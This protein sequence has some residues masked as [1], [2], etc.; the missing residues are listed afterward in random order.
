MTDALSAI[1]EFVELAVMRHRGQLPVEDR[2]KLEALEDVLRD[3]ID[4]SR[5]APRRIANPSPVAAPT[6]G[7]A[8]PPAQVVLTPT[9]STP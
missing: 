8:V 5:P 6:G 4:G 3:L 1:G 7:P 9:G 2:W